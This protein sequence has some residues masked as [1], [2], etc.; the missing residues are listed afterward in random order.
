MSTNLTI[1]EDLAKLREEYTDQDKVNIEMVKKGWAA[2]IRYCLEKNIPFTRFLSDSAMIMEFLL[3]EGCEPGKSI[4]F[5]APCDS[6]KTK[7]MLEEFAT[8]LSGTRNLIVATP[9]TLQSEQNAQMY[10][11]IG[12][13]DVPLRTISVTGASHESFDMSKPNAYSTVYDSSSRLMKLSKKELSK[14]V[15]IVDEAHQ[16]YSARKYRGGAINKLWKLIRM[17]LNAGGTVIFMTGTPSKILGM[18]FDYRVACVR[19]EF[20]QSRTDTSLLEPIH[21][22]NFGKIDVIR[23]DSHEY[24]MEDL[25]IATA[26]QMIQNGETPLIRV[27]DKN[28]IARI[29]HAL[30]M[31][32]IS[33]ATLS[34]D[35]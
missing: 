27:N 6:G 10:H 7:T 2:I 16:M 31:N 24:N 25:T 33:V 8:A 19:T 11:S 23:K 14:I 3:K 32:G 9:I 29:A 20:N 12:K 28:M 13:N 5:V 34:A 35:D 1:Y 17:I 26:L 4:L 15:F 22:R 18:P 21:E 30:R